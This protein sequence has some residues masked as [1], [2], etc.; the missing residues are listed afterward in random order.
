ME[1]DMRQHLD[2]HLTHRTSTPHSHPVYTV[3][4]DMEQDMRQHLDLHYAN[5]NS[6][7]DKVLS[8]YPSALTSRVLR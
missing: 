8:I 5:D 2:L 6:R 3:T 4:Q 7:V 1:P